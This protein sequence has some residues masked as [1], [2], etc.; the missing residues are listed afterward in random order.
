M[1]RNDVLKKLEALSNPAVAEGMARFGITPKKTYGVPVPKLIKAAKETGKNHELALKLWSLDIRETRILA[2]MVDDPGLVTEQ[3]ME[4]WVQ[5]WRGCNMKVLLSQ[6]VF[7][8]I[9][10]HHGEEQMVLFGDLDSGGWP[11]TARD[12]AL[13]TIR[14]GFAFHCG[15]NY[16]LPALKP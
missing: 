3:Q 7:A 6:T 16:I 12:K 15:N 13:E 10:T 5:D 11:K 4:E 14:K 9:A 1:D 2:S 8:N